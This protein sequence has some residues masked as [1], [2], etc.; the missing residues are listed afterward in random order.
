VETT[1]EQ[2][3]PT[4]RDLIFAADLHTLGPSEDLMS[5]ALS[6][7]G[8]LALV[9]GSIAALQGCASRSVLPDAN[10]VKVSRDVPM[11]TNCTELGK[12]SGATQSL[13]GTQTDALEDL[14]RE[15]ANKGANYVVV[16]QYS[17]NG[18]AVTGI[19]YECH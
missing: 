19:A 15:A 3:A 11:G 13:K 18:T 6:S 12:I 7:V 5:K 4:G 17:D 16:K 9:I 8:V 14:K 10:E 1:R 2:F